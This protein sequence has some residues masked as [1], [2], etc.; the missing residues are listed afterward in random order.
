MGAVCGIAAAGLLAANA[1]TDLRRREVLPI[2]SII[3]G[4][5]GF[6][7]RLLVAGEPILLLLSGMIPGVLLLV[8]AR[9]SRGSIGLG[10]GIVVTALGGWLSFWT[11][12]LCVVFSFVVMTVAAGAFLLSGRRQV[13]IPYVPF[14]MMGYGLLFFFL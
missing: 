5:A 6:L 10:D 2:F 4:A 12:F 1:V 3:F 9:A 14:L 11:C 13:Q 7:W 8:L